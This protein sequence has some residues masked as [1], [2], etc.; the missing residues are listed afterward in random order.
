[1]SCLVLSCLVEN[2]NKVQPAHY[3]VRNVFYLV[4]C[5]SSCRNVPQNEYLIWNTV[6][7]G[8]QNGL[9]FCEAG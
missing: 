4:L 9:A 2:R 3:V 8:S 7:F 6:I 5:R 1:M